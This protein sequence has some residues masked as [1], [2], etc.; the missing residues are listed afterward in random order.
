MSIFVVA[1]T[2]RTLDFWV[3]SWPG[4][5]LH[6]CRRRSV[7]V[8]I[9]A[10]FKKIGPLRKPTKVETPRNQFL[11]CLQTRHDPSTANTKMPKAAQPELKK[12]PTFPL[13]L[14]PFFGEQS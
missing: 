8:R 1:A 2:L 12:V 9:S 3:N 7:K 13:P 4:I 11:F 6:L 5:V 10:R 14:I